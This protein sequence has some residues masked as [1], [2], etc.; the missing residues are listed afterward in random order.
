MLLAT[1]IDAVA[2]TKVAARHSVALPRTAYDPK[3]VAVALDAVAGGADRVVGDDDRV[4]GG[5]A[6]G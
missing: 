2:A 1:S 6:P 3:V 5:G 4:A